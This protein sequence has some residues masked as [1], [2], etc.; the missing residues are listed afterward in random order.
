MVLDDLADG[1]TEKWHFHALPATELEIKS[2]KTV[3]TMGTR[4]AKPWN[5]VPITNW[6]A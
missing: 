5:R 3:W 1:T 2:Y 6:P 4:F